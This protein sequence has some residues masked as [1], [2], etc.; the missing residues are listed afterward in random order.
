MVRLEHKRMWE[1]RAE[2]GENVSQVPPEVG[3]AALEAEV[4][5]DVDQRM[6]KPVLTRI[7]RAVRRRVGI[8]VFGRHRG[9]H[10]EATVVKIGPVKNL[11]RNR[12]EERLRAFGLLVID[13]Q[14]DVFPLHGFPSSLV[15][16]RAAEFALQSGD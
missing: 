6:A 16:A 13:E 14:R 1:A 5:H 10:E 4:E 2:G 15:D 3:K 8:D 11:A 9:S 12:I 7:V